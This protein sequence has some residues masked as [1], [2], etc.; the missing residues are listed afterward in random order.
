MVATV[1]DPH[2][3]ARQ[4]E[5]GQYTCTHT[6]FKAFLDRLDKFLWNAATK[7]I[8]DELEGLAFVLFQPFFIGRSDLKLDVRK[9]TTTTRLFLQHLTMCDTRVESLFI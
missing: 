2:L 1:E 6:A 3:H 7:D 5:A 8:I 9:L 4:R